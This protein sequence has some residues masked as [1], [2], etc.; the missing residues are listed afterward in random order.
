MG[1]SACFETGKGEIDQELHSRPRSSKTAAPATGGE[2]EE[3]L[4]NRRKR[5]KTEGAWFDELQVEIRFFSVPSVT[6]PV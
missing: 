2:I 1:N 3:F 6:L 5:S 4:L